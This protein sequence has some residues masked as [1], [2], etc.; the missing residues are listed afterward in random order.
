[1][2]SRAASCLLVV[3]SLLLGAPAVGAG[4]ATATS[5]VKASQEALFEL[6]NQPGDTSKKQGVLYDKLFDDAAIGKDSLGQEWAA[7]TPAERGDFGDLIAKLFRKS[8]QKSMKKILS[9]GIAYLAETKDSTGAVMVNMTATLKKDVTTVGFVMTVDKD[10]S[11]KV[12]DVVF[13][14]VSWVEARR[15]TCTKRIK[16][17]GFPALMEDLK[18]ELAMADQ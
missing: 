17:D 16:K 3:A 7:R 14:G 2:S 9:H 12:K 15:S 11:W 18:N 10:G 5:V 13:A 1:M 4:G 6:L 8:Y